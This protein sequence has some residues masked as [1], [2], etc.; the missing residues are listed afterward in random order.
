VLLAT[1]VVI[2]ELLVQTC[3]RGDLVD[4]GTF[5]PLGGKM[6]RCSFEQR[7]LRRLRIARPLRPAAEAAA[8]LLEPH[9]IR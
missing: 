8:F 4:A 9:R 1:E 7:L 2:D 5:K 3:C 6:L